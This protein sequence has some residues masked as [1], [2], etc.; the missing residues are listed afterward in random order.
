MS[1]LGMA[2]RDDREGRKDIMEMGEDEGGGRTKYQNLLQLI[3]WNIE[4]FLAVEFGDYKLYVY[5]G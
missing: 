1:M 4:Q 2:S 3:I 5:S